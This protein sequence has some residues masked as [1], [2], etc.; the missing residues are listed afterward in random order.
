MKQIVI[1]ILFIGC[2]MAIMPK[3]TI[4]QKQS[5]AGKSYLNESFESATWP[6]AGWQMIAPPPSNYGWNR[7]GWGAH[8]GDYCAYIQ[9]DNWGYVVTP[10]L[11]F[12]DPAHSVLSFWL[13]QNS[14]RPEDFKIVWSQDKITWKLINV[15]S[16]SNG[17]YNHFELNLDS[18]NTYAY[19]GFLKE[20]TMN[21]IWY[22]DDISGPAIVEAQSDLAVKSLKHESDYYIYPGDPVH[23]KAVVQ[24]IGS[25]DFKNVTA[26]F[27]ASGFD[28]GNAVIDSI[29]SGDSAEIYFNWNAV[30]PVSGSINTI[31]IE[32]MI[33]DG[34]LINNTLTDKVKVFTTTQIAEG[35]EK[36]LFPPHGWDMQSDTFFPY[37]WYRVDNDSWG[38]AEEF[39]TESFHDAKGR[40]ITPKLS[41]RNQ[42]SISFISRNNFDPLQPLLIQYSQDKI[43]WTTLDTVMI[44]EEVRRYSKS[45]SAIQGNYYL[46]FYKDFFGCVNLDYAVGP[47]IIQDITDL[48]IKSIRYDKTV[49]ILP[50]DTIVVKALVYNNGFTTI[51]NYNVNFKI[52]NTIAGVYTI[53]VLSPGD[54][55]ECPFT[56][57]A[58]QVHQAKYTVKAELAD[59]FYQPNNQMDEIID[60]IDEKFTIEDFENNS[61]PPESWSVQNENWFGWDIPSA[62]FSG[63][64]CAMSK[65]QPD[66]DIS[67]ITPKIHIENNDK[68][69]FY[70]RKYYWQSPSLAIS[71]S[72]DCQNWTQLATVEPEPLFNRN[73]IELPL[74]GDYYISFSKV[75]SGTVL[76]DHVIL[77]KAASSIENIQIP[78]AVT[79]AQN[80]PNPFNPVTSIMYEIGS[81]GHVNLSIYNAKGEMIDLVVDEMQPAG[82]HKI[83]FNGSCL[84]SG[85]YFYKLDAGGKSAIKKMMLLK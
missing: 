7:E 41:I 63:S 82:K 81:A 73:E 57:L 49:Q 43:N 40:L 20:P 55:L 35:F 60:V 26:T 21:Y 33:T 38:F 14:W 85:L 77:P 23:L 42:D 36:P 71:Y 29:K 28:I 84:N 8:S 15:L 25:T 11:D 79:L 32:L 47:E 30:L 48:C 68:L 37:S 72:S 52:D 22:L 56:W 58:P 13:R 46:A 70:T 6:P 9:G 62:C 19:I 4:V 67:L 39:R 51:N 66:D 50:E 45:L 16:V 27:S 2:F 5:T 59:D 17:G 69:I 76:L 75:N 53:P 24:N 44:D 80:Y 1:T 34:N 10:M 12:T 18:L 64:N 83:S 54:S 74:N 61:F 31:K 65:A 3:S 78:D